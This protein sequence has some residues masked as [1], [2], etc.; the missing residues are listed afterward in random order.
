MTPKKITYNQL[1]NAINVAKTLSERKDKVG[2]TSKIFLGE[3]KTLADALNKKIERLRLQHC[4]TDKDGCVILDEKGGFKFNK[5]GMVALQE[6]IEKLVNTEEVEISEVT[7]ILIDAEKF[8]DL[9]ELPENLAFLKG[10]LF[11]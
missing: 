6:D 4:A 2:H 8:P 9:G 1:I 11:E 7:W 3:M 10:I 5:E